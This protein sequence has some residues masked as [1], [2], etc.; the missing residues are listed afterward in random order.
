MTTVVVGL[1]GA[2]FELIDRWIDDGSLPTLGRLVDDGVSTGLRSCLPPVTCPNWQAYAT[3]TNPGKLGVFWWEYVDRERREIY[4]TSSGDQFDGTHYWNY[5]DGSCAVVNLP[6]SYPPP[7]IDGVHV[8]GGPGAEQT[9]YTNPPEFEAELEEQFDY[10][11]HPEKLGDLSVENTESACIDEIYDLIDAR[12]DA[13]EKLLSEGEYELVHVTVFYLNVLHHFFWDDEIVKAAWEKIDHRL[14]RLLETEELDRLFVMSDHGSNEIETSFRVNAWL[15]REGYL[16]TTSGV[17]DLLYRMGITRDRV[18]PILAATGV[19]W[20]MRRLLPERIQN[21][22]PDESGA[23]TQSAK[24]SVIDWDA[25]KAVASGQGPV[26]VLSEDEAERESLAEEL[27]NRL[28]G[29]EHDG[30]EV[31]SEAVPAEE[32]YE[33]PHC[34][35]GPDLLLRQAPGVHIEGKIGDVEPFGSPGR[36]RAENKETGLFIGYGEEI[37]TGERLPEM[38]I[39]ELAPT[40]LHLHGQPIPESL[41]RSPRT[42]VFETGSEPAGA[43]VT[44]IQHERSAGTNGES[45]GETDDVEKRLSDLGYLE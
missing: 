11:V 37:E 7:E 45:A 21:T 1:D 20:F 38:S 27:R 17:G 10:R 30:T 13:A 42:D 34:R 39:T 12:F 25:S 35:D 29:L 15:E 5:L 26:Y 2:S 28:D 33:G 19:E 40:I 32:V 16:E 36:W 24:A 6:T 14:E 41:D 18:R 4:S 8:A 43:E 31:I 44:T 9:G 23:V 22:L 3:G